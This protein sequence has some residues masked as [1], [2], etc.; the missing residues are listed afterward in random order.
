LISDNIMQFRPI[1]FKILAMAPFGATGPWTQPPVPVNNTDADA[2]MD[3]L[4]IRSYFSI[5][6]DVCPAGGLEIRFA[7]LKDFHP[8][9]ILQNNSFLK[10]LLEAKN[11]L[12]DP[13]T[14][15]L[16][17]Q[18][19][20]QALKKWPDLPLI[21]VE[22]KKKNS[23]TPST[24]TLDNILDMVALPGEGPGPSPE[25]QSGAHQIDHI[26][27]QVLGHVFTHE[28][29]R[30]RE[31]AWGGL[32]LLLQQGG[33]DIE[34]EIVPVTL[35]TL[36]QTLDNLMPDL[37]H[38][39]PSLILM[40]LPFD[41]SPRCIGLLEKIAIFSETLMVPA[42]AWI[43]P[44]F[45][46]M[47]S[48]N[49]LKKLPFLPHFME[50][51]VFAKW[52]RLKSQ[53]AANWLALTCNRFLARYPYGKDNT[54][55]KVQF[56]EPLP[57]WTG[58]VWAASCLIAQSFSKT[59]WPTGFSHWRDI[60]IEDLALGTGSQTRLAPT[61]TCFTED[62][63]DQFKRAGIMPLAAIPDKDI[64]FT[65]AET[66]MGGVPLSHQLFV[67]RVTQIMLW[68]RDNFPKD[69]S[70]AELENGLR[71]TFSRFWE[72]SGHRGPENLEI[73]AGHRQPDD[74]IAVHMDLQP[75]GKILPLGRRIQLDF[76]W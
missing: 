6:V 32:K 14:K 73:T 54:P 23:G 70:G 21:R 65:P 36:E 24:R 28:D 26:L 10:H 35:D 5:P 16:S 19:K 18:E 20:N 42:L 29:F 3:Q 4:K 39:L 11:Y 66:T 52:R 17:A 74:R 76:F 48:W 75:S 41:N 30:A 62:R 53:P 7:K 34:L 47:D 44:G 13:K 31:T 2:A 1:P 8:D 27:Q 25:F 57:P 12:T 71:Q 64:V 60:R 56:H 46:Q 45:M 37:I 43:T 67:S 68:C 38:H 22:S 9:T 59:G 69:L 51:P 15:S 33:K 55:R 49:D 72:F 63:I 50:E 58:P 40:D 61:E